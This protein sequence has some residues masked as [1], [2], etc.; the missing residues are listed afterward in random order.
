MATNALTDKQKE[1][2]FIVGQFLTET[3]R[4]FSKSMLQITVMKAEFI[5][6]IHSLGIVGKQ[7]RAIYRNLE[8]L[9]KG[10]YIIYDKNSLKIS[11]KGLSE[12]EKIVK[13]LDHFQAI[14]GIIRAKK[15]S[16]KRKLQTKLS[17]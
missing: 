14:Q 15:I 7:S 17:Y 8:S 5:D 13:E 4:R 11:K 2:L 9:Q 10:K 1:M 6:A 3:G 12:Y 16:F